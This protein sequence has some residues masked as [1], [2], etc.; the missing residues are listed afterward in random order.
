[1]IILSFQGNSIGY[2]LGKRE[3]KNLLG[4]GYIYCERPWFGLHFSPQ[5]LQ[6]APVRTIRTALFQNTIVLPF[7]ELYTH[8]TFS[9]NHLSEKK[10]RR[11]RAHVTMCKT[12]AHSNSSSHKERDCITIFRALYALHFFRKPLVREEKEKAKGTRYYVQNWCSSCLNTMQYQ[13]L[14]P[15]IFHTWLLELDSC[16]GHV[17]KQN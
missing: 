6:Q 13:N 15:A 17:L 7:S 16:I 1:M 8:S 11:P 14:Y 3:Q 4:Y 10:K 12:D 2:Q 9:E 5:Y